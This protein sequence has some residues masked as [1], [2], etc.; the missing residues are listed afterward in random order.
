MYARGGATPRAWWRAAW[1]G[2]VPQQR[3]QAVLL[4]S[5]PVLLLCH[6][7]LLMRLFE[8]LRLYLRGRMTDKCSTNSTREG[9]GLVKAKGEFLR[10]VNTNHG[11]TSGAFGQFEAVR[12]AGKVC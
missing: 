12:R 7:S 1:M 6:L 5:P 2:I 8:W 3:R 11:D 9:M 10:K 4:P